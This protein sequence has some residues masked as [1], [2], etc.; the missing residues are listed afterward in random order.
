MSFDVESSKADH[1][2]PHDHQKYGQQ[3][4]KR[5]HDRTRQ[6]NA[7]RRETRQTVPRRKN[8]TRQ[9]TT[10]TVSPKAQAQKHH[11]AQ[12]THKHTARTFPNEKRRANGGRRQEGDGVG[13]ELEDGGGVQRD[14]EVS[15][16]AVHG[17]EKF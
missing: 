4:T 9:K 14:E 12:A 13:G 1:I 17:D 8:H 3:K 2:F 10:T 5:E 7:T 11:T 16:V 15:T 6:Y